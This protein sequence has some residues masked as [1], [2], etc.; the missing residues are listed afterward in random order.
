MSK[1][2]N[3]K[4]WV[5]GNEPWLLSFSLQFQPN[6][7]SLH[8]S[9]S[10]RYISTSGSNQQARPHGLN[11]KWSGIRIR[12]FL[13]LQL[14]LRINWGRKREEWRGR[15]GKR[16]VVCLSVS[17]FRFKFDVKR[18][19]ILKREW[20]EDIFDGNRMIPLFSERFAAL[21]RLVQVEREKLEGKGHLCSSFWG[22][23]VNMLMRL[24]LRYEEGKE[25]S[26]DLAVILRLTHFL[27]F[28]LTDWLGMS[29]KVNWFLCSFCSSVSLQ[30]LKRL[31][32]RSTWHI[33]IEGALMNRKWK[34]ESKK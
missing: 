13:S 12:K 6:F 9:S 15:R 28:S 14:K 11:L 21:K 3:K 17:Q 19:I 24:D 30:R 7:P 10:F 32:R 26:R 16:A 20:G 27:P 22:Q 25:R 29:R 8:F 2:E 33:H 31:E 18:A 4:R 34:E 1:K 5:T 23:K